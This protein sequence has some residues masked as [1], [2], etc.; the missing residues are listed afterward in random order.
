MSREFFAMVLACLCLG[1][2]SARA[3]SP[4]SA[5]EVSASVEGDS[6]HQGWGVTGYPIVFYSPETKAAM[7]AGM[8]VYHASP[9]LRPD[10]SEL[11]LFGT[12]M[13]QIEMNLKQTTFLSGNRYELFGEFRL[14]RSPNMAFYGVG[15]DNSD[16][17]REQYLDRGIVFTPRFAVQLWKDFFVGPVARVA[18]FSAQQVADGGL[19][20]GG[21]LTG[22]REELVVGAGLTARLETTDNVFFPTSG[23]RSEATAIAHGKAVGADHDFVQLQLSHRHY[24][25]LG[26]GHV[27]AFQARATLSSGDVPW[28]M[29]PRLGGM[30]TLRGYYEGRYRDRHYLAAQAEYRFP[31]V[32]RFSGAAF[33]DVGEVSSALSRLASGPVRLSGGGGLRFLLDRDEHINLRVDFAVTASGNSDFYIAL[34]EA[35]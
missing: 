20:A 3:E 9:F 31:L 34:M 28:Q 1:I 23:F 6:K 4:D 8:A 33:T 32:W 25:G 18:A 2:P 5:G 12:Q 29:V 10:V 35:F 22:G 14:N 26:G 19:I 11:E 7:G 21:A 24:L 15:A 16:R 27:L 13:R 17:L 30:F